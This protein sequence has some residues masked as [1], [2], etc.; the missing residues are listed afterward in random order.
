MVI[1]LGIDNKNQ[2]DITGQFADEE[3]AAQGN[4]VIF[5]NFRSNIVA[6]LRR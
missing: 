6:E 5:P 1:W 2:L 4:K 3:P